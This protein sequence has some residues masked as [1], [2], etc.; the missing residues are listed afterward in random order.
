MSK[1]TRATALIFGSSAGANQLEQFGSLAAGLP[2]YLAPDNGGVAVTS[3]QALSNYLTGWFGGVVGSNA[4]SIQDLNALCYLFAYQIAYGF[5]SGIPEYDAGTTYYTG[6]FCNVAGVVYQSLID[7]NIGNTPASSTSDWKVFWNNPFTSL[8]DTVY[9]AANGVPTRLAGN[10]AAVKKFLGQKGTGSVSAAPAWDVFVPPTKTI[11]TSG[12]GTYTLP[13]DCIAIRVICV[14]GGGGGGGTPLSTGSQAS[15]A[16]GG[17]GGGYVGQLIS[18]PSATY[19]YSVGAGGTA[20]AISPSVIN[21]GN[22]GDSTF[23]TSLLKGG[24]GGGGTLGVAGTTT[25]AI[26]PNPG[27]GGT[28]LGGDIAIPGQNGMP[29]MNF[30]AGSSGSIVVPYGGGSALALTP[31]PWTA[32][33]GTSSGPGVSPPSGYGNG[34]AGGYSNGGAAANPGQ[35][36]AA[37]VIIIEEYYQ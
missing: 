26:N 37:G 2:V 19:A 6:S 17:G 5:Q 21:G 23:G 28:T 7:S 10:T 20:A 1:I 12:S 32:V 22:G 27:L 4:P 18:S 34:G 29:G 15:V 9:S 13:T 11:L 31:A 24:G 3:I 25:N 33:P 35:A 30:V 8:G 14:G 36:G 16:C